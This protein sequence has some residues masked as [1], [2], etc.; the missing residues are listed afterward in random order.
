MK[1]QIMKMMKKI[2]A[3]ILAFTMSIGVA[4]FAEEPTQEELLAQYYAALSKMQGQNSDMTKHNVVAQIPKDGYIIYAYAD[5]GLTYKAGK[6]KGHRL[7]GFGTSPSGMAI[8][9][10]DKLALLQMIY[11]TGSAWGN[12][13]SYKYLGF[14]GWSSFNSS[15][16]TACGAFAMMISDELYGDCEGRASGY[17]PLI[18]VGDIAIVKGGAVATAGNLTMTA[19]PMHTC[20]IIGIEGDYIITADGNVNGTVVWGAKYKKSDIMQYDMRMSAEDGW[21]KTEYGYINIQP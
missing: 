4:A 7:V 13:D 6:G 10:A 15:Y 19:A 21:K 8:T 20:V 14:K 3:I 17:N 16:A 1:G 12:G 5:K 9:K 11:P 18:K 2:L